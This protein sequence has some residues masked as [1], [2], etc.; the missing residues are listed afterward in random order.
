VPDEAVQLVEG[1]YV[2]FVEEHHEHE[3]TDPAVEEDHVLYVV[4]HIEA[5]RR[6]G[7]LRIVLA[8]LVEGERVVVKGAF[9]LKAEL[10]KGSAAHTHVH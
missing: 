2:V 1:E 3:P 7:D 6:I 4:R 5:G 8:G 10:M 9:N